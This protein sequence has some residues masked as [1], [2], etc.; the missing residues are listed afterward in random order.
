MIQ[1]IVQQIGTFFTVDE[2]KTLARVCKIYHA[3]MRRLPCNVRVYNTIHF[4]PKCVTCNAHIE[5]VHALGFSLYNIALA[6]AIPMVIEMQAQVHAYFAKGLRKLTLSRISS[7]ANALA[8]VGSLMNFCFH[9]DTFVVE[10]CSL[11]LWS[12][13]MPFSAVKNMHLVN[14]VL[15]VAFVKALPLFNKLTDLTIRAC[16]IHA[17]VIT[18]LHQV[19]QLER[20]EL[21]SEKQRHAFAP[22]LLQ[23]DN[24]KELIIRNI[25]ATRTI[26]KGNQLRRIQ[27]ENR[28]SA[29]ALEITSASLLEAKILCMQEKE[30]TIDAPKLYKLDFDNKL[31]NVQTFCLIANHKNRL[32]LDAHAIHRLVLQVKLNA[33][34]LHNVKADATMEWTNPWKRLHVDGASLM[35]IIQVMNEPKQSNTTASLCNPLQCLTSLTIQR[36]ENHVTRDALVILLN[37]LNAATLE[38]LSLSCHLPFDT[39]LLAEYMA[40]FTRL[41]NLKLFN[42]KELLQNV[43]IQMLAKKNEQC[44]ENV[45]INASKHITLDAIRELVGKQPQLKRLALDGC[46]GIPFALRNDIKV[47]IHA[48]NKNETVA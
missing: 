26:I 45:E 37:M 44:L 40:R 2:R 5:P 7:D 19:K 28:N 8:A 42:A 16:S 33:L 30:I 48:V 15:D 12:F 31:N 27:F 43:H 13:V 38:D 24:I 6:S 21:N 46:A 9:G 36:G 17:E 1:E 39:E 20:L 23:L 47:N 14:M 10:D 35:R 11:D 3:A 25:G 32:R 4:D 22:L 41:R 34:Y 18:A 29:L